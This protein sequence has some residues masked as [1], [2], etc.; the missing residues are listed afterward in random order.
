MADAETAFRLAFVAA[1]HELPVTSLRRLL[2]ECTAR[3][4]LYEI[5][6]SSAPPAPETQRSVVPEEADEGC[7]YWAP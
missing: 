2:A 5:R 3:V 6:N 7:C 1:L 4:E